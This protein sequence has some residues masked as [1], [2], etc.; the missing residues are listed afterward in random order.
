[1]IIASKI[2]YRKATL[3]DV[4]TLAKLRVAFINEVFNI[5]QSKDSEQLKLEL[6]DYFT[7]TLSAQSVIAWIAEYENRIVSTSTLVLWHAPPTYTGLG[8]K[9]RRGYILNMYTEKEFRK[10]GIA[11]V[12][13]DKLIAEAKAM[14]LEFVHLHASEDGIGIYR[15]MGFEDSKFPELNLVIE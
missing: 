12:L 11:S 2:T 14:D 10:M 1:M 6:V 15:K 7:D 9:G 4:D 3:K 8:K 5:K 13:L